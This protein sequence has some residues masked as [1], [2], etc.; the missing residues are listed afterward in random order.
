MSQENVEV[1]RRWVAIGSVGPEEVRATVAEFCD[2]DVDYYPFRK[3]SDARPCRGLEESSKFLA[4][5]GEAWS[6]LEWAVHELIE[7]GD[8]RVSV[9][10]S[11]RA[12]GRGSGVKLEGDLYQC[13]W[14]RHGRLVRIEDHLTLG[15]ASMHWGSRAKPSKPRG[16][17]SRRVDGECGGHEA[18]RGRGQ[19]PRRKRGEYGQR[20]SARML[21]SMSCLR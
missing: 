6:R 10:A 18:P 8:E 2:A 5:W 17:G 21:M 12:E 13:V 1:V 16:C 4:G 3:F 11:L 14:L 15:A 20:S 9:C 19:S 7:V